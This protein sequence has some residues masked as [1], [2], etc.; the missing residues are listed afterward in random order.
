MDKNATLQDGQVI[1]IQPKRAASKSVLVHVVKEGDDLWSISQ[2]YGVK[3]S[4]L[5]KY[6]ALESSASL[7]PGSKV[8]LRKPRNR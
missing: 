5:A 3:L 7:A 4:R 2:R 6:N 1:F 8:H